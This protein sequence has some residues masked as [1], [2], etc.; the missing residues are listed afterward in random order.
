MNITIELT[1]AQEKGLAFVAMSPQEWAENAVHERC[2]IAMDEIYDME[3]ARMTA[4]PSITSIPAD[5]DAV[6]LAADVQTAAE[7]NAAAEAALGGQPMTKARE[8]SDYTGLQADI[9]ATKPT[10]S[11]TAPSS[12]AAG[13]LWFDSTSTVKSMKVYTGVEWSTMSNKLSATGGTVTIAGGY[14]IHTFTS[15]GTFVAATAG[16]VDVLVVGGGGGGSVHHAGGGGAG[17]VVHGTSFAVSAG[18]FTATIGAGAAGAQNGT[19]GVDSS[20]FSLIA[21]GGGRGGSD[22]QQVSQGGSGG[23]ANGGGSNTTGGTS[24]QASFTGTTSYGNSGGNGA[25]SSNGPGNGY[26]G[27]GGGGAGA[28]GSSYSGA[29]GGAG[30][31]GRAFSISGSSVYYAGGGGGS[32]NIQQGGNSSGAGGSGGGGAATGGNPSNGVS[33]SANTGG[34]GGAA[35]YAGNPGGGGSGIIVVRYLS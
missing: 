18:S 25:G 22:S 35:G 12:P 23:G 28:A 16:T 17:G 31:A 1:A 29:N 10:V 15:S 33:G 21:K 11:A 32:S 4:D 34:G 19:N 8:N 2:R 27:G 20:I 5:K 3:V 14:T 6:V 30:G 13:D 26:P 7:R 24:N 9:A